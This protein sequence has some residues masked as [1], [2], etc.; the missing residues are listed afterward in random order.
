MKTSQVIHLSGIGHQFKNELRAIEC[1]KT[2]LESARITIDPHQ[3]PELKAIIDRALDECN[4][5]I[6]ALEDQ[7]NERN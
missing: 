6:I 7:Y 5:N 1:A 3:C 2:D 4:A